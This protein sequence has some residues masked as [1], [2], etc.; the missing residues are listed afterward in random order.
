MF[1]GT[2]T[3]ITE[4]GTFGSGDGEFNNSTGV[5]V[6]GAGNIYTVDLGNHRIQVFGYLKNFLPILTNGS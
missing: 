3:Y 1:T 2:G 6:W 5:A 4:W